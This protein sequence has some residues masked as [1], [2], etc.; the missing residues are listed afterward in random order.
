[1]GFPLPD[2]DREL[3]WSPVCRGRTLGREG[4]GVKVGEKG[5][6]SSRS[7]PAVCLGGGWR[8]LASAASATHV[9]GASD[10]RGSSF[11]A[12]SDFSFSLYTFH[13]VRVL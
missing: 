9:P 11:S 8:P 5:R 13:V 10:G 7:Q 2:R 3:K 6:G 4:D 1:M 12:A